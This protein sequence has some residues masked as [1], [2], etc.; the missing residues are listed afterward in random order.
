MIG[1]ITD[2]DPYVRLAAARALA[3]LPP[4][5]E[6]TIPL[7]ERAL[8]NAD[9]ATAHHALDALAALGPPAVPRLI[10][11]LKHKKLRSQVSYI[12]G[13]IG[14]PAA[15]ATADLAKLACDDDFQVASEAAIALAKIGPGAKG[16]V[17][18]L[19]AALR[20]K[21]CSN[22]RGIIYA[23]GKI[24][25]AATAAEPML[26]EHMKSK[27]SSLAIASAWAITQLHPRSSES[28]AMATPVLIAGLSDPLPESR[29][30]AAEVL[31]SLGPLAKNSIPALQTAM[32][33]ENQSVRNS[34]AE[35]IRLVRGQVE[36]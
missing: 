18:A 35:A 17:P 20:K 7:F 10:D 29:Q 23:L 32:R 12:L 16:A 19:S 14:P 11:V 13:E 24:G 33:D 1:R 2:Q 34:A 4:A 5:P 27:D 6:I 9:E 22:V 25:P 28:A 8:Q 36:K 15:P 3:A 26:L 30:A 31:G 21:E